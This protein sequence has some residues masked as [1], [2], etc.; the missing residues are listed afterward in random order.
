MLLGIKKG[1][2]KEGKRIKNSDNLIAKIPLNIK[3]LSLTLKAKNIDFHQIGMTMLMYEGCWFPEIWHDQKWPNLNSGWEL[4]YC[5][6]MNLILRTIW[7]IWLALWVLKDLR[8][9]WK[10]LEDRGQVPQAI[11]V[12]I[13]SYDWFYLV[14]SARRLKKNKKVSYNSR[15]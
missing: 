5:W 10:D 12:I 1:C 8:W 7:S 15:S 9:K 11:N 6:W 2:C 13:W 3:K 4:W 14:R